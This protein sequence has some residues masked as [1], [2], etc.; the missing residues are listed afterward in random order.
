VAGWNASVSRD[1][2]AAK[3]PLLL[4]ELRRRTGS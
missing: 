2:T 1:Q 3:L 4:A